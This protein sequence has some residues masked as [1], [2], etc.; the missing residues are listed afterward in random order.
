MAKTECMKKD[1]IKCWLVLEKN[2]LKG[3]VMGMAN[4]IPGVSGGTMAVA[5]GIYDG[6]IYAITHIKKEFKKSMAFLLPVIVGMGLAIVLAA[7]AISYCLTAFPLATNLLFVGLI[8]GGLPAIYKKVKGVKPGAKHIIAFLLF[9][10]LVLF[11]AALE[12]VTGTEIALSLSALTIL[13]LFLMGILA[14]ATMVIPG[15]SGSMVLMVLGY[16]SPIIETINRF[17]EDLSAWNTAGLLEDC[18]ILLPFGL[19]IVVGIFGIA[20][21][22][23]LVFQKWERIA[24]WAI[25]GLI[26]A[27]PIAIFTLNELGTVSVPE[28]IVGIFLFGLGLFV[29]SRLGE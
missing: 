20:K 10:L 24:Y 2:V 13:K 21:L 29:A 26:F 16:Y 23:E 3:A 28:G 9:F 25:L 27:S 12:G 1:K 7:K 17:M 8:L 6:L 14:S 15:I 11:C 19:G 22:L 18:G 5:M 4:V